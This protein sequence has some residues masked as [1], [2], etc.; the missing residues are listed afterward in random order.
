MARA[1]AA[2]TVPW[3]GRRVVVVDVE[4]TGLSTTKSRIVSFGVA[5]VKAG[6]VQGSFGKLVNP[7]LAHIGADFIHGI[8]ADMLRGE[9]AFAVFAPVLLDWFT[10]RDGETVM[11]A[12]Q[13]VLF[14]ALMLN[15]ELARLGMELPPVLLL[16]TAKVAQAAGVE[17]SSLATL[18]A[19]LGLVA[20]DE[21]TAIADAQVTATA[22]IKL[23]E[24]MYDQDPAWTMDDLGVPFSPTLRMERSGKV[25]RAD[26]D[27][28]P[29]TPEHEAAHEADMT[30][31]ARREKSL[32]VC[33]AQDC[34]HLVMRVEDGITTPRSAQQAVEWVQAQLARPGLAHATRGRLY[35]AL[36]VAASRTNDGDLIQSLFTTTSNDLISEPAC[37]E[38]A[39]CDRCAD[40]DSTRLCR[41]RAIRYALI[42]AFMYSDGV[43]SEQRAHGF[44]PIHKPGTKRGRG[45]PPMGW[46]GRLVN[47]GHADAAGY[48]ATLVAKTGPDAHTAGHQRLVLEYAWRKGGRGASLADAYSHRIL[49]DG[50]DEPDRPHLADALAICDEALATR[51]DDEGRVWER[52]TSR[53]TRIIQRQAA[54]PRTPPESVRNG[55]APR[56]SRFLIR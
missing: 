26:S 56:P 32:A 54:P 15:A 3:A 22:L 47:T 24:R 27:D 8:T 7:G 6:R 51:G 46:F 30:T 2:Q 44:L 52:I 31:K 50:S 40:P 20:L 18:T 25:S 17:G 1:S 39:R 13:N 23:V 43:L 41:F 45:H 4:T 29:L 49:G 14:D 9:P 5:E 19:S 11:L 34:P 37:D 53:R 55:R 12:G 42:A 28:E 33:V 35:T 16:D 38:T 10:P 48:G 36:G 21:H